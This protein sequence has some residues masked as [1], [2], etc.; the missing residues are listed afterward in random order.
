[1][2]NP[3]YTFVGNLFLSISCKLFYYND[4]I[5]MTSLAL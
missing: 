1:M 2:K 3:R 5:T 4:I